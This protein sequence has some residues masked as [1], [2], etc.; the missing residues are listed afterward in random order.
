MN[1]YFSEIGSTSFVVLKSSVFTIKQCFCIKHICCI[2]HVFLALLFLKY[3]KNSKLNFR[4]FNP[5]KFHVY[6][7]SIWYFKFL[8][9]L[10]TRNFSILR[11]FLTPLFS[12][13]YYAPTHLIS[14]LDAI[15]GF[16]NN[17]RPRS[18]AIQMGKLI[19]FFKKVILNFLLLSKC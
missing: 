9:N 11:I 18:V 16:K 3:L 10:C 12:L 2:N 5:Q 17:F 15:F 14:R 4:S 6:C 7:G 8:I 1:L 13:I 19:N